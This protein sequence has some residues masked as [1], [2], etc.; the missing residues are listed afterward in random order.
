MTMHWIMWALIALYAVVLTSVL[1]GVRRRR[2]LVAKLAWPASTTQ[3]QMERW[4]SRFLKRR[5]WQTGTLT[6]EATISVI[7]CVKGDDQLFLVFLRDGAFFRRLMPIVAKLGVHVLKRMVI[8]L[9]DPPSDAMRTIAAEQKI[10]LSHLRDLPLFDSS[11]SARQP[12]LTAL[13]E[14]ERRI[15]VV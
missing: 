6:S 2:R 7:H 1:L 4:G 13:R 9:Y 15:R 11:E 10:A 8:V 12:G 5:G 14:I 3:E